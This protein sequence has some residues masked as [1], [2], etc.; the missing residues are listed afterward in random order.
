MNGK[1][2]RIITFSKPLTVRT[3]DTERLKD[4]VVEIVDKDGNVVESGTYEEEIF[5][6]A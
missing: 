2:W 3:G 5:D 4:G 6:D 1:L